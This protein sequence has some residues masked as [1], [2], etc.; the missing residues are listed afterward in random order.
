MKLV[1]KILLLPVFA[2]IFGLGL[3]ACG[4]NG[5]T[6][7]VPIAPPSFVATAG[8][9]KVDLT[10]GGNNTSIDRYE[11][12]INGAAWAS[13]GNT[14]THT[15]ENLTNGQLYTFK[16]RAVNSKGTSPESTAQATPATIASAP[17][18]VNFVVTEDSITLSWSASPNNG[19][20]TITK[21]Q[22]SANFENAENG[23]DNMTW[24][25]VSASTRTYTYENFI[26]RFDRETGEFIEENNWTS[27]TV[28]QAN[29]FYIRAVTAAG[30]GEAVKIE[31][32]PKESWGTGFTQVPY[33]PQNI[34]AVGG[35]AQ[36]TL[37]WFQPMFDGDLPILGY[38]VIIMDEVKTIQSGW[39]DQEQTQPAYEL[40]L[41]GLSWVDVAGGA[42]A[43]SHTF[44]GLTNGTTYWVYVVA[45]NADGQGRLEQPGVLVEVTPNA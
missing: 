12:S 23:F 34:Q 15:L 31:A 39:Y 3:V 29:S 11:L 4:G 22:I 42:T 37:T 27:T 36:A 32:S 6:T 13:I 44:S 38:R 9:Q 25:D 1:K 26:F 40:D 35:N 18:S 5:D 20:A 17:Q 41:T 2:I 10:W 14:H 19:G 43:R 24:R 16:L 7:T 8:N 21:Y 28:G 30:N 45:V 33:A